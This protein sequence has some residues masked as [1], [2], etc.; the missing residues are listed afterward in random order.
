MKKMSEFLQQNNA[1]SG[2]KVVAETS[3]NQKKLG[4]LFTP[5]VFKF[6]GVHNDRTNPYF[7]KIEEVINSIGA[8]VFVDIDHLVKIT[9][10]LCS[11]LSFFEANEEAW[12]RSF[13]GVIGNLTQNGV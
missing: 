2:L 9:T 5:L 6:A 10:W 12:E 8:D 3:A 1:N 11:A 4:D 7:D 13:R